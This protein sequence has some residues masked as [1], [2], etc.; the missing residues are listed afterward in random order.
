ME[1]QKINHIAKEAVCILTYFNPNFTDKIPHYVINKLEKLAE[2]SARVLKI[3]KNKTLK[4]QDILPETK[5]LIALIYYSYIATE[6]EKEEILQIWNENEILYQE[7][8]KK[9]YNL[10]NIFRKEKSKKENSKEE[11]NKAM[12]EYKKSTFQKIFDK[13]REIFNINN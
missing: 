4:E 2:K 13:I 1:Q 11:N 7:K 3:D 12:V 5:D 10:E 8:I 9:K 6:G